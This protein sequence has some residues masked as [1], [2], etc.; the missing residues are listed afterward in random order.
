[1]LLLLLP[2]SLLFPEEEMMASFIWGT[3]SPVRDASAEPIK[4]SNHKK[5]TSSP[6]AGGM[7]FT[8]I[9]FG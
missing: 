5:T 7:S 2:L 9:N 4:A 3:A 1:M 8:N 6:E